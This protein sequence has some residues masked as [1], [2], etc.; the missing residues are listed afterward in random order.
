MAYLSP[1]LHRLHL[2]NGVFSRK[3]HLDPILW[4]DINLHRMIWTRRFSEGA[5]VD[6]IALDLAAVEVGKGKRLRGFVASLKLNEDI[7]TGQACT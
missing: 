4:F 5:I 6:P 2:C 7:K 3:A 1:L